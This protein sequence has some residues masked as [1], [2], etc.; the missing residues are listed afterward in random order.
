MAKKKDTD[1]TSIFVGVAFI[2]IAGIIGIGGVLWKN[3]VEYTTSSDNLPVV[4][5][6]IAPQAPYNPAIDP[7]N[8]DEL[9]FAFT[10]PRGDLVQF[11]EIMQ[12][13][14]DKIVEKTGKNAK[15]DIAN[16][17]L[18][19]VNKV[20]RRLVDFGSIPSMDYVTFRKKRKIKAVLERFSIPPKCTIFVVK[21]S[22]PANDVKD[23]K[24]Y[25]IAYRSN[26]SLSGYLVPTRELKKLG[27]EHSSFFKQE[28]FSENYSDSVL[29]LQNDQYDCIILSSNFFMELPEEVRKTMKVAH[30]SPPIPGGV[31]ITH[32]NFRNPYE[33]IIIGSMLKMADKIDANKMFSGMFMTRKPD[34][35][36][37][38][39][40]EEEYANAP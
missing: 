9:I 35:S 33:Q 1:R 30:E 27:I 29:G 21:A 3:F 39:L 24:G 19:I 7:E 22:D 8:R 32:S 18:E 23:L 13:I 20:E 36:A 37:F 6:G 10:V 38:D 25:R 26:D 17:E 11:L 5:S 34:E 28:L 2:L 12:P 15:I 14:L 40:L 16:N 4:F 31:Y